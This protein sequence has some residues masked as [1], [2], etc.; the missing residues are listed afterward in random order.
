MLSKPPYNPTMRD[1]VNPL[2]QES[3]GRQ[4]QVLLAGLVLILSL[5]VTYALWSNANE[6][7]LKNL[8]G[9]FNFRTQETA[10]QIKQ[11]MAT[12]Q[13]VLRGTKSFM[14]SSVN[15]ERA[16]FGSYVATLRLE[17]HFPGIQAIGYSMIVPNQGKAKHIES[18]RHQG[19]PEYSIKPAGERD[20]YTAIVHIEPF[21]VM[22]RRAFGYDMFSEPVRR[23]AMEKARDSG[24][25][26]LSGKVTLVQEAQTDVQHGFLMYLPI[27]EPGMPINTVQERRAAIA[28]WVYAPFRIGDFMAGFGGGRA[29]DLKITIYDGDATSQQACLFN[30][31]NINSNRALFQTTKLVTIAGRLWTVDIHSEP[32]YLAQLDRDKPQLLAAAGIGVSMLLALLVWILASGKSRA[33][34]LAL[35]MTR[36]LRSSHA[37]IS[38]EQQRMKV[39]LENSHDAF[40]AIDTSGFVTDWNTQAERTFGWSASE[41]I[42]KDLATLIIPPDQREAHN[43]GLRQFA[44][45]GTGPVINNRIE[46]MAL[47]RSGKAI[48]VELAVAA[49]RSET[50]YASNAFIRDISERKEAELR[51]AQRQHALE[52]ART[53]LHHAQKLEAVGKLTGGVAHDFNNV[54]QIVYGSIQLLLSDVGTKKQKE[55]WLHNA[56]RAVERGGKLSSQLLAFARRQPLQPLVVNIGRLVRNMDDLL[57][58]AL[59]ESIE[60]E[61]IV[62]GGL[63]NTLVDPYQ[64]ENVILNLAINARDAM[65]DGGKLTIELGNAMLDDDYVRSESSLPAGQYVVIAVSDTGTGMTDD[66]MKHIFEPFFTTKREGEG[67]G[68]GL[69][70]AYGFVNQSGGHIRIDSEVGHGTKVKIYLPRSVDPEEDIPTSADDPIIGGTETILVVEDDIGVQATVVAMLTELGYRVLKADNGES[71][72]AVIKSGER[73]DLLFTDVVMPGALPSPELAKRAKSMLPTIAVLFTSGYAQN[74]I[75]HGGRLDPGVQLLSKPYKREQLARKVR[76]VIA[77]QHQAEAKNNTGGLATASGS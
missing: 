15:V 13:Q 46:L 10:E 75:V 61:T 35:D 38:A 67:T 45:S 30:C 19:F 28:G 33:V 62:T 3:R 20:F 70:M 24:R 47:H 72:L 32:D 76:Q 4:A 64:L 39:I 77:D 48:P 42:G 25:A 5:L 74:A 66:V 58:R 29:S 40:V 2:S 55:K 14:L 23:E 65:K 31:K 7:A 69:S 56:L 51:E 49:I 54:L 27:Y 68:L 34:A 53:A 63:W 73:I 9:D 16:E 12:Y 1:S 59:G 43:T 18:I 8:Q 26:A 21:D 41:A 57:R 36:E 52:D 50:K 71:A 6:S 60:I 17:E 37:Q 22:N 44:A 11:R